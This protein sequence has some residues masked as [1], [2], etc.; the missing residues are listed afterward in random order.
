[1]SSELISLSDSLK[2]LKKS[3]PTEMKK[4]SQT[5]VAIFNDEFDVLAEELDLMAEMVKVAKVE[6]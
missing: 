4:I 3:L 5:I 2:Q 6:G 1:M